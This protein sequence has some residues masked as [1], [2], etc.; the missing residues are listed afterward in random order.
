[1]WEFLRL[2]LA[3]CFYYSGLVRLAHSWTRR[4]GKRLIILNYHRASGEHLR[5]QILYLS[6]HYRLMHLNEALEELYAGEAAPRS[7]DRRIPLVLTFD[8]GYLDNYSYAW[9]LACELRIPMTIFLVP[10]YSESG[11]YFWWLATDYLI[12][13]AKVEKVTIDSMIYYLAHSEYRRAL[14]VTIDSHLRYATSVE[15]RETFLSAISH[16]LGVSLPCR[17][18]QG[19][20]DESL[21]LNWAEIHEMARS[22]WISF[23]A[24]TM[25]HPLL[26]Y[27]AHASETW[28]EVA[29]CRRVLEQHTGRTIRSFAYPIGKVEHIGSEGIRAVKMAG[30]DWAV[31]TIEGVNTPQTDPYLLRRLPGDDEQHWLILASELV[32]L[33]GVLSRYRKKR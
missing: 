17:S 18:M 6:R 30:Y 19:K 27:L 24:H 10:G 12:K 9:R 28:Y 32:G 2:L 15:E 5:R 33:L 7:R 14:T 13:H 1:M 26:R 4:A 8:D 25:H 23:A 22:G 16:A 31:T 3:A 20:T 21:P 11:K 29:E